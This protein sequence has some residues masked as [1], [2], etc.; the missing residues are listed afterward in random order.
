MANPSGGTFHYSEQQLNE[1]GYPGIVRDDGSRA[2]PRRAS[3]FA[4]SVT[5]LLRDHPLPMFFGAMAVGFLATC[6]LSKG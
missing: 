4:G 5:G 6:L 1:P 3:D 2:E